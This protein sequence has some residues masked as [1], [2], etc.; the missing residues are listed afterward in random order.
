MSTDNCNRINT[1][2]LGSKT[3]S[4]FVHT[5]DCGHSIQTVLCSK[6]KSAEQ[7]MHHSKLYLAAC[8][9]TAMASIWAAAW[10]HTLKELDPQIRQCDKSFFAGGPARITCI[11]EVQQARMANRVPGRWLA[12]KPM[13]RYEK[14]FSAMRIRYRPL[15]IVMVPGYQSADVWIWMASD[16]GL[17]IYNPRR[18]LFRHFLQKIFLPRRIPVFQ[19]WKVSLVLAAQGKDFCKL[20]DDEYRVV[21]DYSQ[22]PAFIPLSRSARRSD[23]RS[24]CAAKPGNSFGLARLTVLFN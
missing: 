10:N 23:R 1:L 22:S 8:T 18:S 12:C 7:M 6:K 11:T 3:S 5:R 15:L 14:N 19:N 4:G 24:A 17:F 20:Y 16:H 21:K 2:M 9:K 13:I